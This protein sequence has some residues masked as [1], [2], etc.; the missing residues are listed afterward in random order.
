MLKTLGLLTIF[1]LLLIMTLGCNETDNK[2]STQL[3]LLRESNDQL[4]K[5]VRDL[6]KD[7][8]ELQDA[9][10][11]GTIEELP[12][13]TNTPIGNQDGPQNTEPTEANELREQLAQVK[14]ELELLRA[15]PEV[16]PVAGNIC[17]RSIAVQE[18]L[19][20]KLDIQ[21]CRYITGEELIRVTELEIRTKSLKPGDFAGL[22]NLETLAIGSQTP[23]PE[24]LF[25]GLNNLTELELSFITT[26]KPYNPDQV[27]SNPL[28]NLSSLRLDAGV[29]TEKSEGLLLP[30][31]SFANSPKLEI[32]YVEGVR[33]VNEKAL[34]GLT[35]LETLDLQAWNYNH[36][37]SD[38]SQIL[39]LPRKLI[40]KLPAIQQFNRHGFTEPQT[41]EVAN[42]KVICQLQG[43][44][45]NR[46]GKQVQW[47]TVQEQPTTIIRQDNGA[48]RV[49]I[50]SSISEI[51]NGRY[52]EEIL[53]DTSTPD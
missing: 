2:E 19:L 43:Y 47:W 32:L 6:R 1:T 46:E 20:E 24:D 49:G 31:N 8:Q 16:Q 3:E 4:Q 12:T 7:V 21:Y 38:P 13:D 48:C 9:S 28:P 39:R 45:S 22:H 26:D 14:E 53:I 41:M 23:P 11:A 10:A 15:N 37:T 5:E 40:S 17:Q 25:E 18:A 33:G 51:E 52:T 30:E 29:I 35:K 44:G 36:S 27:F 42:H 50:A 34:T